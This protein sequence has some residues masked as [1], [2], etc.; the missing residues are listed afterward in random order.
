MAKKKTNQEG[1]MKDFSATISSYNI[2]RKAMGYKSP[3]G[4]QAVLDLMAEAIANRD[5][6]VYNM[7]IKWCVK[8]KDI[9]EDL[10]FIMPDGECH[11]YD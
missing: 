4:L 10:G 1:A 7:F 5:I 9:G 11:D 3:M 2:M 8:H 6:K